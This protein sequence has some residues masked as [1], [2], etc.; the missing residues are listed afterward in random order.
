VP[1]QP[2]TLMIGLPEWA[3]IAAPAAVAAIKARGAE[4][5]GYALPAYAAAEIAIAADAD[6]RSGGG[7]IAGRLGRGSFP[8][9]IGPLGFDE[10]GDLG[11]SLYRLFRFDGTKFV[12]AGTQ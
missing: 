5:E 8:T 11:Q 9:A 6:T 1:L 10:K 7:T 12:E 2:G 3:D 4:A